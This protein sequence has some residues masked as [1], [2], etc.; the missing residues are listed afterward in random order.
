MAAQLL[1]LPE[2]R[3]K[4]QFRQ[5]LQRCPVIHAEDYVGSSVAPRTN[6]VVRKRIETRVV[7]EKEKQKELEQFKKRDETRVRKDAERK[8]GEV[9][10]TSAARAKPRLTSAQFWIKMKSLL[11]RGNISEKQAAEVV[12]QFKMFQTQYVSSLSLE[13]IEEMAC[14]V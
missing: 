9:A 6:D 11:A 13:D 4:L 12:Q 2:D 10:R 3:F 5:L 1:Q 7:G 8:N 14:R